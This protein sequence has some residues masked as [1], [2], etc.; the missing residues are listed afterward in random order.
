M[1]TN[2]IK[3]NGRY[4][5]YTNSGVTT[6]TS[7]TPVLYDG[8]GRVGV[9]QGDILAGET[10]VVDTEGVYELPKDV[11]ANV[12]SAGLANCKISATGTIQL[13]AGGG[14]LITNSVITETSPANALTVKMKL[15]G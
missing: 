8:V 15:F 6:I 9:V 10:G 14:T 2:R 13:N 4:L 1:A 7:G 5:D 3:E 12:F 11:A